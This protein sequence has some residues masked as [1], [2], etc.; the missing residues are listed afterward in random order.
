MASGGVDDVG[1]VRGYMG[2]QETLGAPSAFCSNFLHMEISAAQEKKIVKRSLGSDPHEPHQ[3]V[4]VQL[5][6][7]CAEQECDCRRD[8]KLISYH[9][10]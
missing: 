3:S 4:A 9:G 1:R 8:R 6:L 5:L 2:T 7:A 10:L